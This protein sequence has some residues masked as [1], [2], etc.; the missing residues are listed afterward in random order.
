[1]NMMNNN[2]RIF[3]VWWSDNGWTGKCHKP[4]NNKTCKKFEFGRDC[5]RRKRGCGSSI[6]FKCFG[7]YI[8]EGLYN[9]IESEKYLFFISKNPND[10]KYYLIGY[11]YISEKGEGAPLECKKIGAGANWDYYVKGDELKSKMVYDYSDN[12][13]NIL[14]NKNFIKNNISIN[15]DWEKDSMKNMSDDGKIGVWFKN[16]DKKISDNDANKILEII[17]MYKNNKIDYMHTTKD[18]IEKSCK[19]LGKIKEVS[20]DELLMKM[21]EIVMRDGISL[22]DDETAW[23]E[24]LELNEE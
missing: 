3:W 9:E 19:E 7:M 17:P 16:N 2:N 1:M 13:N 12:Q 10:K 22:I 18:L 24:I 15:L 6:I 11:F 20:K 21:K 4:D 23:K 14:F 8:T 5:S